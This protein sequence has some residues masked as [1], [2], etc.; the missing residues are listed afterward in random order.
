MTLKQIRHAR[1]MILSPGYLA[2]R[3]KEYG[4]AFCMAAWDYYN[5]ASDKRESMLGRRDMLRFSK[6]LDRYRMIQTQ[7]GWM[8]GYLESL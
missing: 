6:R 8:D 5:P 7:Y 3:Q 1:K 4:E 2:M